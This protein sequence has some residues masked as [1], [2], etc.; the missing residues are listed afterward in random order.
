MSVCVAA[1]ATA[2]VF[3][4]VVEGCLETSRQGL[5]VIVSFSIFSLVL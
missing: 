1:D 4:V 3:V 2:V 5:S